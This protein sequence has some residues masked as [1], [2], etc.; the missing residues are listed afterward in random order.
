V[1][2]APA[3]PVVT[4]GRRLPH[5]DC[6]RLRQRPVLGPRWRSRVPGPA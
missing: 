4:P 2:S 5:R 1:A 6:G 3:D